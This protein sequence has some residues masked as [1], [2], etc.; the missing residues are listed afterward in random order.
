M[1]KLRRL[2]GRKSEEK[3]ALDLGE[4]RWQSMGWF[5]R[6]Q[7]IIPGLRTRGGL[8]MPKLQP[9]PEC[10]GQRKRLRK[11]LGGA[12]YYCS[13]CHISFFVRGY[14]AGREIDYMEARIG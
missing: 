12:F 4:K 6:I 7:Y 9:C 11:T 2:F 14:R 3:K 13:R 8:N 10:H 1:Q 5:K